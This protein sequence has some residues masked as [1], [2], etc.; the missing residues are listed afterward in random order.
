MAAD[1]GLD[2][3]PLAGRGSGPDGRIVKVDVERLLAG[4]GQPAAAAAPAAAPAPA[5]AREPA[6][7]AGAYPDA[8][9][10]QPSSV[11]R[12]V[13]RRMAEA[14]ST[15]PHFYL[16]GEIDMEAAL[17]LRQEL[18][19][20]LAEQGEKLSVNDLVIRACARALVEHPQFHRSW[21]DG[22]LLR[23]PHANIGLAVALDDGLIVPVLRD[24]DTK[25][26]REIAREARELAGRARERKLKQHEIVGGTFTVSNLGMFGIPNFGA[27]IN[28]PEP[29]ILAVGAVEPRPAV[30]DG[31]V[32]ARQ[33]MLV[34]LSIDHRA[35]SGAD[36]ARFLGTVKRYLEAPLL[37]LA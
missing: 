32:V 4:G 11:L 20:A 27:I 33:R 36:G 25:G 23:H 21:V 26:L 19:Q 8:E 35:A 17:A 22:K 12:V 5:A 28:P 1:A 9:V 14:K 16:D 30:V 6:V 15:V 31:Q 7:D 24:A 2:L 10:Q 3:R 34:R 37:M 29:G 18:N 13:A